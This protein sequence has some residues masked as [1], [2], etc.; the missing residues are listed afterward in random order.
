MINNKRKGRGEQNSSRNGKELET[1]EVKGKK[2]EKP[3]G[4]RVEGYPVGGPTVEE[5]WGKTCFSVW[6]ED[7]VGGP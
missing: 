3:P 6:K 5:S 2:G 7:R 4:P 1:M